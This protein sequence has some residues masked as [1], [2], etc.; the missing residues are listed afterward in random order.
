MVNSPDKINCDPKT[1]I[2]HD[3]PEDNKKSWVYGTQVVYS[4]NTHT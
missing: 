1:N 3:V 4:H 2:I